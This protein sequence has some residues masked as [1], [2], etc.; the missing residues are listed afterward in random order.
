[1]IDT[2]VKNLNDERQKAW[3]EQKA[4]LDAAAVA[5]REL[6]AEERTSIERTDAELDRL[7]GEIKGW[8]ERAQRETEHAKALEA[9]GPIAHRQ[10]TPPANEFDQLVAFMRGE[11]AGNAENGKSFEI[12]ITGVAREKRAIRAGGIGNEILAAVLR[13]DPKIANA[14]SSTTAAAGGNL[15]PTDFV[16][17]LYDY[18]E[19]FTGVRR[20]GATIL[21]TEGGNPLEFPKVATG[22]TADLVGEGTAITE[23]DPS[24]GKMTLNSWKYGEIVRVPVELLT[25]N[26][27]DLEGF[28]A[29]DFGRAIGRA[30]NSA[31]TTGTGSNQPEGVM[32]V[33]GTA[34]TGANGGTGIFSFDDLID[35]EYAVNSEYAMN[36]AVWMMKRQT[37]GRARKLKNT[38]GQYLWQ[39]SNIPGQPDLLDGY[40][41]VENP[42]MAAVGTGLLSVAFGDFSAFYIRDVGSIRVSRSDDRYFDTD[43]VG[44]K[45][46]LRTDSG[47]IDLTG[48]VLAYRGG[49]A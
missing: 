4:L 1:M 42:A 31:Y 44:W 43:E 7:D 46:T 26:G 37:I 6:S 32:A 8:L 28:L 16:R 20:T 39:P 30:T 29:R 3:N 34:V 10:N 24:F 38:D 11:K 2:Y 9:Y 40:S 48:A 36:G 12:D 14:L 19:V 13:A 25:D 35:L 49:T 47:L 27:V 33:I 15:V 45:A 5:R 23:S 22:G 18:L 17:Q 21:T 41:V